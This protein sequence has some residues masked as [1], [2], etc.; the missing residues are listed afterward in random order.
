MIVMMMATTPS[1]KASSRVFPSA[2]IWGP[3]STRTGDRLAPAAHAPG[4]GPSALLHFLDLGVDDIVVV[5]RARG[6]GGSALDVGA[7][8]AGAARRGLRR[9]GRLHV[10]V[11]LLA[12][13]LAG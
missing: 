11:H 13:L 3:P 10:G 5:G 1:L 6:R 9:L 4:T 7:R 8:A 12:Q 2:C